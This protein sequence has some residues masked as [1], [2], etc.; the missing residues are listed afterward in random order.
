MY[1]LTVNYET[2]VTNVELIWR[3]FPVSRWIRDRVI[4]FGASFPYCDIVW[5]GDGTFRRSKHAGEGTSLGAG[6][7][8]FMSSFHFQFA[9]CLASVVQAIIRQLPANS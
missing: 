9:L 1:C 8:I 7:G 6:V 3:R 5:E 2:L 4:F